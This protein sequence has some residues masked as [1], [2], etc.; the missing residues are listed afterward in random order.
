M[1]TRKP[2]AV[3]NRSLNS[4]LLW[5]WGKKVWMLIWRAGGLFSGK[6]FSGELKCLT[7][8]DWVIKN[9]LFIISLL[10]GFFLKCICKSRAWSIDINSNFSI[11]FSSGRGF[12][13]WLFVDIFN[14]MSNK[15]W[16][17]QDQLWMPCLRK[18]SSVTEQPV[19]L[20]ERTRTNQKVYY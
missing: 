8:H 10:P 16:F 14:I 2:H 18:A 7:R 1:P 3:R 17:G 4:N 6:W 20:Y 13:I 15:H 12:S 11:N 5:N 19:I 9:Y